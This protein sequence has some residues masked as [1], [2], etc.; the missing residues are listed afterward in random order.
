MH[1]FCIRIKKN[2]AKSAIF[3]LKQA[4]FASRISRTEEPPASGERPCPPLLE[5]LALQRHL[6]LE[7]L[8]DRAPRLSAIG[9]L[10]ELFFADP[11]HPGF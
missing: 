2:A 5:Q 4:D 1:M 3:R 6:R 8:R 7:Q 10:R 11:R 9:D